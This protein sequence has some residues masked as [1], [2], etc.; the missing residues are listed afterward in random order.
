M[1]NISFGGLATG[2]NSSSIIDSLLAIE[3]QPI[4]RLNA[5]KK[6]Q[7]TKLDAVKKFDNALD[8]LMTKVGALS[9]PTS[10]RSQQVTASSS[11]YITATAS[12]SATAG[13][14]E[15]KVG[16]LA[17][18]EKAVYAG[19]AD[20]DTTAFGT[21]TLILDNDALASPVNITIDSSNNTLQGIR[22][23]I[24]AG[25]TEHGVSAA[26]VNDGSGTPYRL[27]LT[28]KAV[29]NANISLDASGL[30]GGSAFP[31]KDIAVSRAAQTAMIQVDGIP[32]TSDTNTF[33]EAIPGVTLD[34]THAEPGFNP[35]APNWSDLS[36][37]TLKVASDNTAVQTKVEEFVAAFNALVSAAG[38]ANLSGDG[39]IRAVMSNLRGKFTSNASGTGLF[40]LGI[41]SQKDGTLLL[42]SSKLSDAIKNDMAGVETLLAGS[43]TTEGVA[44]RLQ[45]SLSS[46]TN[47]I[48][49]L[50][51]GRQRS[52]DSSIHR[53]DSA[54]ARN[55]V[56]VASKEKQLT[57][58]F[59]ALESLV[60]SLNS[61]GSYLTQQMNVMSGGNN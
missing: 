10:L 56:R 47:A 42:K 30:S 14:Y 54:I 36:G 15:V 21:G 11:D 16:R 20:R 55:E 23:A 45:N 61:Q 13:A 52:Y 35:L 4:D 32:I 19:V 53:I 46:F 38:D 12:S 37:T 7:A 24:N 1:G 58:Q 48:S 5:Q 2:M 60:S 39:G 9:S 25:S 17:Q 40:Q 26:I 33:S 29:A 22:D 18:V 44:D 6:A 59:S 8:T 51:A 57:D 31:A 34:I 43:S 49:G 50:L 28:G 3:R 27:V 41:A